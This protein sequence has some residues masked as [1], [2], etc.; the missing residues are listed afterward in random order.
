MAPRLSWSNLVPGLIA[1]VVLAAIVIGVL[2]FAGVGRLRGDTVRLYIVTNQARGVMKGT[3]VWLAGQKVGLVGDIAFRTVGSDTLPR[4]V[5]AIDVR[6]NA[7][8]QI[9]RDAEI[10]VRSGSSLI[11]P[12]VVYVTAGTPTAPG[13]SAG[14]TLV[15]RA[16]SDMQDAMTRLDEATRELDPLLADAKTV[17]ASVRSPNGTVGA[18][19][20]GGARRDGEIARLRAQVSR[21]RA[22]FTGTGGRAT[23][24][25]AR[26][27]AATSGALARV[28]SVR[29]LVQSPASSFGRFR[30]DSTLKA[31]VAGVRD[32]VA[33][34]RTR[35]AESSGT[36]GRM[37]SDSALT[38]A[39]ADAQREMALLFEDLRKRPLRYIAF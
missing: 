23:A 9:R 5:I 21:L 14:D 38:R 17:L 31:S 2:T 7:A 36:L 18:A 37:Q 39:L 25:R 28:D 10:Q 1:V 30:R 34:L 12:M 27:M 35:L 15:A 11:G 4:V 20:T 33:E 24:S 8:S 22:Q 16:Q 6:R 29:T 32:E 3:E 26:L 13:A 19:R